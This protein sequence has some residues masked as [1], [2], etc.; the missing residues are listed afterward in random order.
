M[1]NTLL[2]YALILI[3]NSSQVQS[4]RMQVYWGVP[5]MQTENRRLSATSCEDL[6]S[7]VEYKLYKKGT[8]SQLQ[9]I[10]SSWLESVDGYDYDDKVI[11]IAKIKRKQDLFGK[12]YIFC[13]VPI[14]N[15]NYFYNAFSDI[16][17]SYGERFHKAIIDYQCD[18]D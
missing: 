16:S 3:L 6:I 8:V 1:N 17:K 12:K 5:G 15:W 9:L 10:N 2:Y 11:V 7:S 4:L 14:A 18:C 13:S